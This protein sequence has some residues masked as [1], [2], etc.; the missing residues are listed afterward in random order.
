MSWKR[1][2]TLFSFFT[3]FFLLMLVLFLGL[4]IPS[5]EWYRFSAPCR[6]PDSILQ[7]M[8]V[9]VFKINEAL[10][11]LQIPHAI[12]YGTLW[13]TLRN[14]Q[15]LPWDNN[16]DFCVKWAD[17]NKVDDAHITEIFKKNQ[18]SISYVSRLGHYEVKYGS[19][20]GYITVFLGTFYGEM[21]RI[22]WLNNLLWWFQSNPI[23]FPSSLLEA[24]L[25]TKLLY[26]KNVPVPHENIEILKYLYPNDWWLEVKPPGCK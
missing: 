1:A 7:D 2:C 6:T 4:K 5:E 3:C 17:I 16:V 19:A 24:P 22:G 14:G 11:E 8:R 26:N 20:D 9:L 23:S 18:L 15:L 21:Y 13:G 25:P 12:C 10:R